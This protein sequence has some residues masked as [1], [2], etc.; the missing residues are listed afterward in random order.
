VNLPRFFRTVRH[1]RP[2]QIYGRL[3]FRLRR[4]RVRGP[5]AVG[6]RGRIGRWHDAIEVERSHL[7]DG[8][9]LLLGEE[10][11]ISAPEHWR[12]P[13]VEP[14]WIYNLHYFDDLRARDGRERR[15]EQ[16]ALMRR[17][18]GENPAGDAPGWDPYPTSLR[19]VN[20]IKWAISGGE[21]DP[22]L[23][24][25][26][27]LQAEHLSLRIEHHIQGNHLLANAKGLTFAGL[28]FAGAPAQRWLETGLALFEREIPEQILPD[29]GHFEL[30][31]MYHAIV[32][33]DLLD[34]VNL[35]RCY[36]AAA[37]PGDAYAPF[38]PAAER[39]LRWLR[40]MTHPDGEIAFFNDAAIG[41][42]PAPAQ[43]FAYAQRLGIRTHAEPDPRVEHLR[44]SGY[45]R[46]RCGRA[47]LFADVA[48][49]GPDYLPGHAHADTLSFELS[50]DAERTIVNSGTSRYGTSPERIRQ[51]STSAHNSV[52]ID[53]EGSSEVWSGFRV[54]RRA[55]PFDL[56]LRHGGGETLLRCSHD[57]YRHKRGAPVHERRWRLHEAG[58]DVT[59]V[60]HGRFDSARASYHFAPCVRAE[61][62]RSGTELHLFLPGQET[63]RATI[64]GG[65]ARLETT[66]HHPRFSAA[67]PSRVLR[68]DF[69]GSECQLSMLWSGR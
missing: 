53:G 64:R 46:M 25:S 63:I 9:F 15:T 12:R 27:A 17:W 68:I 21:L 59:D 69:R 56:D 6:V 36:D 48:R 62:D 60:I 61:L 33:E 20:W 1:L 19:I 40:C 45:V 55:R 24:Q 31:P 50:L 35:S 39:M 8:R 37:I 7:G 44:D 52:E 42:A 47:T 4:P 66:T 22:E 26:L 58:L 54:G 16:Q 23:E 65:M 14:L 41:V 13:D 10:H 34:V 28:F 51:R 38:G 2:I 43:L 3:L 11:R 29:G 67:L 30:S 18:M 5:I 49:I 57:G 32:L